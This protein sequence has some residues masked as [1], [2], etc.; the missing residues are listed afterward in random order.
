MACMCLV[1]MHALCFV[2]QAPGSTSINISKYIAGKPTVVST[3]SV[4]LCEILSPNW[5]RVDFKVAGSILTVSCNGATISNMSD[6]LPLRAGTAGLFHTPNPTAIIALNASASA[7]PA[8]SGARFRNVII[9]RGCDGPSGGCNVS[10]P[11]ETCSMGCPPFTAPANTSS[12]V[13]TCGSSGMWNSAALVCLPTPS[14]STSPSSTQTASLTPSITASES[15]SGSHSGTHSQSITASSTGTPSPSSS[16]TA[17]S[18]QIPSYSDN[19]SATSTQNSTGSTSCE[20]ICNYNRN[21][22]TFQH[23]ALI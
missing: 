10:L 23:A 14:M 22:N 21:A 19:H 16:A 13:L 18:S 20:Y 5:A 4:S 2:A 17:T 12:L 9:T 11:G 8:G 3:R 15:R 6:G 7:I 1:L